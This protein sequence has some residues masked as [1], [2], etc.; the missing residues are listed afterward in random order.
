MGDSLGGKPDDPSCYDSNGKPDYRK[1]RSK[2][3]FQDGMKQ[4]L[5]MAENST[6][7]LMCAEEDPSK[8]HRHL[9]IGPALEGSGMSFLHIRANGSTQASDGLGNRKAYLSQ[10][11]GTLLFEETVD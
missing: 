7:A 5:R 1:M 6:T 9:L 3:E 10:L 4:L 11:Q 8:C 2:D